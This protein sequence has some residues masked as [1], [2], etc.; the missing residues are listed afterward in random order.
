[1]E[2]YTVESA[3]INLIKRM[4][5]QF[6]SPRQSFSC[7]YTV[8]TIEEC[9]GREALTASAFY[10][11]IVPM[12]IDFANTEFEECEPFIR[13][14]DARNGLLDYRKT[15]FLHKELLDKLSNSI[16]RVHSRDIVI[17][18]GGEYIGE[19]TLVPDYYT[20][21][22]TCRDILVIKTDRSIVSGEYLAS[23]L[24]SSYGKNEL[25]RTKSVQGQ[26][27]LTLDKVAEVKVPIY[28]QDFQDEI[29]V[30]WELFYEMIADS[31]THLENARQLFNSFLNDRLDSQ[32]SEV[33]FSLNMSC[34]DFVQRFDTEYYEKKWDKLVERLE[35]DGI[36]FKLVNYVKQS[37]KISDP[38]E[39]YNYITLSDI[40]DRS[41]IVKKLNSMMAYE[42]PDRAKRLTKK[43]DVLVSS[44][45]GSKEKIAIVNSELNNIV[46]STGFYVVRDNEYL[47]EVLYL[48]F[49]SVYYD[50]FIE[51]MSS[52]AIMSSITDKYF[53]Q[54]KI[55]KISNNVQEE[56][57]EEVSQYMMIRQMAFQSLEKAINKFDL[58]INS[59]DLNN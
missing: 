59:E 11:S 49:R 25:I 32:N 29:A 20:E 31:N 40:D 33:A 22:G 53:K 19:A 35:A 44:L 13:V 26:P 4:D 9:V 10:P 1:M 58:M 34:K 46:A 2:V 23:Y 8:K 38:Q 36:Q 41:G 50:M 17:T 39:I 52:G 3:N 27:H 30:C 14:S 6:W 7:Q 12:Y 28:D 24:Q 21:Y 15:V 47:P 5:F 42:L 37:F 56:I 55:P 45:K 16:K 54:F 43:G 51:Q 57:A 48:I 18:K